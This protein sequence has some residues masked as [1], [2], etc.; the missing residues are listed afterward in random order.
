MLYLVDK[1][2]AKPYIGAAKPTGKGW[3]VTS[4]KNE[5][6]AVAKWVA[7][8]GNQY[9]KGEEKQPIDNVCTTEEGKRRSESA[10]REL[11]KSAKSKHFSSDELH[12][13]VCKVF[14]EADVNG[15]SVVTDEN[16]LPRIKIGATLSNGRS[17]LVSK[18][19][20]VTNVLQAWLDGAEGKIVRITRD[21]LADLFCMADY[22]SSELDE[23]K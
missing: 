11:D 9:H 19:I 12:N 8:F 13:D 22:V 16:G 7:K 5:E 17:D 14:T 6:E 10:R 15:S 1:G 20:A 4:A 2:V 21:E 18:A 3:I 23:W